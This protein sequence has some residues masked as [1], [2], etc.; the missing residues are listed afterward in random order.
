VLCLTLGGV[1]GKK[2][3]VEEMTALKSLAPV[4]KHG[5]TNHDK[6]TTEQEDKSSKFYRPQI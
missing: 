1:V 5:G 3:A 4:D 6:I 2:R